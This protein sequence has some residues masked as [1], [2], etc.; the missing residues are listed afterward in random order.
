MTQNKKE[1][2]QLSEKQAKEIARRSVGTLLL[3]SNIPLTP[4]ELGISGESIEKIQEY[5]HKFGKQILLDRKMVMSLE[6]AVEQVMN[7]NI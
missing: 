5:I 4:E 7:E 3:Q 1:F 6:E 2:K